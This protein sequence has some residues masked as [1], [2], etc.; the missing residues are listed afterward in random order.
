M[1]DSSINEASTLSIL[2]LTFSSNLSWHIHISNT[3]KSAAR[4]LGFLFRAKEYFSPNQLLILYKSQIRPTLEYS[5]HIWGGAPTTTLKL[6]DSIQSRAIRLIGDPSLT[7]FHLSHR[8]DGE[9][10]ESLLNQPLDQQY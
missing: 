3:A 9:R 7:N 8:R 2:G 4:K 10:G 6:L 5:S 1:G